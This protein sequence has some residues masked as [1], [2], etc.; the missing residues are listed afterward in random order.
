[1]TNGG[2]KDRFGYL[3]TEAAA[4]REHLDQASAAIARAARN[5]GTEAATAAAEAAPELLARAALLADEWTD[6]AKAQCQRCRSCPSPSVGPVLDAVVHS[7]FMKSME[8]APTDVA[9]ASH[10]GAVPIARAASSSV[11]PDRA[12]ILP[13]GGEM[14]AEVCVVT[15]RATFHCASNIERPWHNPGR[16]RTLN[17]IVSRL[18][19]GFTL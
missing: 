8:I 12:G 4:L 13:A 18:R 2:S 14:I 1:M 15:A 19:L 7:S 10:A 6:E 9:S 5:E 3:G 17:A 11:S 16:G